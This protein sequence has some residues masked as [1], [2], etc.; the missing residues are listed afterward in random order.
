MPEPTQPPRG[1]VFFKA[2][3]S[4]SHRRRRWTFLALGILVTAML[5]WPLGLL[6]ARVFPLVLGLPFSI[7]WI[8]LALLI[9]FASLIWLFLNEAPEPETSEDG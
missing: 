6:G 9:M 5:V 2:Q 8:V 1:L 7:A 3:D 4:L